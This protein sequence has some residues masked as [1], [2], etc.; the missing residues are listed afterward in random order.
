LIALGRKDDAVAW[1]QAGIDVATK[2]GDSH[3]R[4]ELVGALAALED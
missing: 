3:A 2:A 1:Y 4:D